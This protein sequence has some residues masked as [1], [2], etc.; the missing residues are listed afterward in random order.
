MNNSENWKTNTRQMPTDDIRD[1]SYNN[2][3]K[4]PYNNNSKR[5]RMNEKPSNSDRYYDN[6]DM[7][8]QNNKYSYQVNIL[9]IN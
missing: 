3:N 1:E 9:L 5:Q 8:K 6:S 4:K 7:N 2:Y